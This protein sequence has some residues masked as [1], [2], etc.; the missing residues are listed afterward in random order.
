MTATLTA[1]YGWVIDTDHYP[2]KD[3]PE[4]T[5]ANATG[6]MG[7]GNIS[8]SVKDRLRNGEGRQFRM[9]DD[10]GDLYYSGRIITPA[11]EEGGEM[12]FAPLDDFGQ[13]NAGAT[14][15]RYLEAGRWVEL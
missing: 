9:F 11:D 15:I 14:E 1:A 3:A 12:D 4:G 6:V 2:D 10:D 8:S 13:P 7:P 5:N